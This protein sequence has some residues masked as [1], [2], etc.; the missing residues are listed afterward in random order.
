MFI[1]VNIQHGGPWLHREICS[2]ITAVKDY[3]WQSNMHLVL[4][5]LKAISVSFIN[6]ENP[7]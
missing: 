7:I 3:K 5:Q 4:F 2:V 6:T 1:N